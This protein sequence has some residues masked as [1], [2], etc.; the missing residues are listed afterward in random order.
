MVEHAK[1][2]NKCVFTGTFIV[3]PDVSQ[4]ANLAFRVETRPR[5]NARPTRATRRPE[6]SVEM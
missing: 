5:C 2:G 1:A 3:V 4:P 6:V